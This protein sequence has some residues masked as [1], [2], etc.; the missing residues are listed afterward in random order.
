MLAAGHAEQSVFV[1]ISTAVCLMLHPTILWSHFCSSRVSRGTK[2]CLKRCDRKCCEKCLLCQCISTFFCVFLH[3]NVFFYAVFHMYKTRTKLVVHNTLATA[4][5][6]FHSDKSSLSPVVFPITHAL[7]TSINLKDLFCCLYCEA[8]VAWKFSCPK[9][10]KK[11][12]TDVKLQIKR[13]RKQSG[14][15][16]DLEWLQNCDFA[17]TTILKTSTSA[18]HGADGEKQT[19]VLCGDYSCVR[20]KAIIRAKQLYCWA[21]CLLCCW[22]CCFLLL[23]SGSN[24]NCCF[25]VNL[26]GGRLLPIQTKMLGKMTPVTLS[27]SCTA[28]IFLPMLAFVNRN[29]STTIHFTCFLR[30]NWWMDKPTCI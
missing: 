11:V 10:Y 22:I 20:H 2:G 18:F 21:I 7:C 17:G 14:S 1:Q 29:N 28:T 6:Q 27:T 13:N 8:N 30:L 9:S 15:F 4:W 5:V 12:L 23:I 26:E 19:F 25:S 3:L 24:C 16:S